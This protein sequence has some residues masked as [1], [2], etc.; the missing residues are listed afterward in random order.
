MIPKK[1]FLTEQEWKNFLVQASGQNQTGLG[2]FS[3]SPPW[4]KQ[5]KSIKDWWNKFEP[6]LKSFNMNLWPD[7]Y[8]YHHMKAPFGPFMK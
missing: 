4:L 7:R 1:I 3:L 2:F 8:S 6:V 5:H